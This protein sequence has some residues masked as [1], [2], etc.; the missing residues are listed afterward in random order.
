MNL[1]STL[2]Q[3]VSNVELWVKKELKTIDTSAAPVIAAVEASVKSISL[4]DPLTLVVAIPSTS[5]VLAGGSIQFQ[6]E[7]KT[8]EFSV[9]AFTVGGVAVKAYST[10]LLQDL[11]TTGLTAEKAIASIEPE[12][13]ALFPALEATLTNPAIESILAEAVE[14]ITLLPK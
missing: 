13:A 4:K 9:T 2:K 14:I 6:L 10:N 1:L 8:L 3:D 7:L 5:P 11:G 12:I